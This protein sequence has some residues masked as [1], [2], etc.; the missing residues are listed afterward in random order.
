MHS[1]I[2]TQEQTVLWSTAEYNTHMTLGLWDPLCFL[3]LFVV[4][5][6]VYVRLMHNDVKVKL[7][8]KCNLGFFCECIWVKPLCINIIMTKEAL[9]SFTVFS[10]SGQTHFQ[11]E[12]LGHQGLYIWTWTMRTLFMYTEFAKKN[13]FEQLTLAVACS[14]SRR[15]ASREISISECNV[16]CR[17]KRWNATVFRQ[18]LATR[19]LTWL[20][21]AFDFSIVS[22]MRLFC[23]LQ[24]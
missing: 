17:R 2:K 6:G 1:I 13:L 10:F 9:L 18:Q 14:A 20:F 22:Y 23:Q 8:P 7:S 21:P 3:A 11:W 12:C 15:P 4:A 5:D 16:T 24:G 19:Y